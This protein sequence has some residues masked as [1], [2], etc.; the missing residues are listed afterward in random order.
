MK[1]RGLSP[2]F[3]VCPAFTHTVSAP[4]YWTRIMLCGRRLPFGAGNHPRRR[5][6]FAVSRSAVVGCWRLPAKPLKE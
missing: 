2:P 4:R 5:P 3:F 1:G 6:R